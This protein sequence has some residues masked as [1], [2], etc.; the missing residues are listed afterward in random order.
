M[1]GISPIVAAVLLIAVTMSLAGVLA[2]WASQFVSQ[3]LPEVNA[4]N[5]Q[6]KFTNFAIYNCIYNSTSDRLTVTL[7]NIQQ[8]EIKSLAVYLTYS[9][10]TVSPMIALNESLQPGEFRSY[11]IT[12][13]SG[14]FSK[15]IIT[16]LT[17]PEINKETA[18]TKS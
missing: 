10:G 18:C 16:S 7:N 11:P 6:C 1:K 15:V 8:I 14:D 2:Y 13:V 3:G 5:T 17:C 9:N 4:T 12:D